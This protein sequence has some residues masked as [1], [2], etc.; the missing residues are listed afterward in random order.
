TMSFSFSANDKTIG[1][2]GLTRDARGASSLTLLDA[3]TLKTL[4]STPIDSRDGG[5]DVTAVAF[6]PDGSTLAA[7]VKLHSGTAPL[8]RVVLWNPTGGEIAHLLPEHDTSAIASLA[9]TPDGKTLFAA[10]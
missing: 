2:G 5:A 6:T 1:V 9:F 3:E 8:V 4:K 7:A 10:T